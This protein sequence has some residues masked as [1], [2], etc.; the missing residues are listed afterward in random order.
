ML[1]VLQ[2]IATVDSWQTN[3]TNIIRIGRRRTQRK[4]RNVIIK[5]QNQSMDSLNN[6]TIL[7]PREAIEGRLGRGRRRRIHTR[8]GQYVCRRAQRECNESRAEESPFI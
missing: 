4:T 3:M 2:T 8:S 7:A 1:C 5:I 6:I